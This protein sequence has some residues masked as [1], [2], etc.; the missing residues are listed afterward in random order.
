[1]EFKTGLNFFSLVLFVSGTLTVYGQKNEQLLNT[2]A[3]KIID[4]QGTPKVK[5]IHNNLRSET[6]ADRMISK[7][8]PD[9]DTKD[10][11]Y[12]I[13]VI[14]GEKSS[15]KKLMDLP[16][17]EI[18]STKIL[19]GEEAVKKYGSEAQSGAVIVE[20]KKSRKN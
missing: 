9:L 2:D 5:I 20:T 10:R 8:K 12:A 11:I 18:L 16:S 6:D 19:K 14:D 4:I 7:R 1:M 3:E 17:S 13:V 15:A